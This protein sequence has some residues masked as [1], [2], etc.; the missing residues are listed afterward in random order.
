MF[1]CTGS[2]SFS[3]SVPQ[4]YPSSSVCL[5]P[6]LLTSFTSAM[7]EKRTNRKPQIST[8]TT[9]ETLKLGSLLDAYGMNRILN[10][11]FFASTPSLDYHPVTRSKRLRWLKLIVSISFFQVDNA[12]PNGLSVA[13]MAGG[14]NDAQLDD[15]NTLL[16]SSTRHAR[17]LPI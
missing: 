11:I 7:L 5:L 14:F 13:D 12:C 4:P 1:E 6:V 3:P 16:K 15:G 8:G 17:S 9:I 2:D 10:Q